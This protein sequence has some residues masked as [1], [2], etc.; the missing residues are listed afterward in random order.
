VPGRLD[1]ARP[2]L[3]AAVDLI[4]EQAAHRLGVVALEHRQ[5]A[6]T[7]DG[8]AELDQHA[9]QAIRRDR[10]CALPVTGSCECQPTAG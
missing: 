5:A 1:R 4:V 7:V 2:R 10:H 9:V 8:L 6:L 3:G